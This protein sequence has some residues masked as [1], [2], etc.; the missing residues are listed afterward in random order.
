MSNELRAGIALA[1]LAIVMP[2]RSFGASDWLE[3]EEGLLAGYAGPTPDGLLVRRALFEGDAYRQCQLV[4]RPAFGAET[5]VF[6]RDEADGAIVVSRTIKQKAWTKIAE[7]AER[8]A[9]RK[10]IPLSAAFE[11]LTLERIRTAVD[12]RTAPLDRKSADAVMDTC[13]EVLLHTRYTADPTR[14]FDG[15]SYHAGHWAVGT[16]LAAKTWSPKPGTVAREFVDMEV[17]LKEYVDAEPRTRDATRA[18]LLAK[19]KQLLARVTSR[20]PT[21]APAT[22]R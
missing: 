16:F 21:E 4:S 18:K 1:I 20:T 9:K 13:R 17:V 15:V 22:R 12:E 10:G 5:A 8:I 3:P 19:A 11:T 7:D 14:G 2:S 6:I